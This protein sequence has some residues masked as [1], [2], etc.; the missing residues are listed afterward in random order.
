[1]IT[2]H[3]LGRV[4]VRRFLSTVSKWDHDLLICGGGVVGAALAADV[5]QRTKGTCNV[6]IIELSPPKTSIKTS[7]DPPDVRVYALSPNSIQIL[8]RIGA[9]KYI[10]ERSHPYTNM[11]VWEQSGPGLVKFSANDINANELGRICEDQTIQ[12]AI[13][14]AIRDQGHTL[15]TYFGY[16]VDDLALPGNPKNPEGPAQVTIKPKDAT[17]ESKKLSAR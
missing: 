7:V 17:L 6:G 9:W 14:Q 12:S 15:T 10:A 4:P 2:S 11:Q 8:E 13:Y 3:L 16:A 5:L 1:M